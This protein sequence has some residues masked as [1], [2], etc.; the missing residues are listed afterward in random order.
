M[1]QTDER[2][3]PMA[4][5]LFDVTLRCS[6]DEAW[7]A[8]R[9]FAAVAERL[10][11]GFVTDAVLDGDVRT[12]TF[13]NGMVVRERLVSIDDEH[14]RLVYTNDLPGVEHH[15]ASVRIHEI[16]GDPDDGEVCRLEWMTDVLPDAFAGPIG[17]MM[18]AGIEIVART[19][20]TGDQVGG[21]TTSRV[22]TVAVTR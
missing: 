19:L 5:Q 15:S 7:D 4:S 6:P 1:H 12:V 10:A 18:A 8:V 20:N 22:A 11:P 2:R 9:D 17:E 21:R 3:S 13:F 14:R 16:D